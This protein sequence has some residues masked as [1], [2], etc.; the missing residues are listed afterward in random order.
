MKETIVV[1]P[2]FNPLQSLIPFV[3]QLK[4]VEVT[5]I[6]IVND[7]SAEKY[8]SV[9]Q[10]LREVERCIVLEHPKNKGK[11]RALKTGF[12]YILKYE[13]HVQGIVTV[14]AHGQHSLADIRLILEAVKIFSDGIILGIR[15]FRSRNMPKLSF[16][17]NR[18]ASMLF[19]LLFHRRLLDIQTGLRYIPRQELVW[20]RKVPGEQFNYD[21]NMLVEALRR[22]VTIYEV[23]I[24]YA[25]LK[26]NS[27][28][29]YDEIVN[30]ATVLQQIWNSFKEK[31]TQ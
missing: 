17:G 29:S 20:L 31:R 13:S 7:G 10:K 27:I 14:G 18:A 1:I 5:K 16:I 11:G 19:E 28:I 12:E 23:P 15:E 26:K 4:R 24:G 21:T 25:K 6:I 22:D 30:P 9:F 2:A 3:E 8:Q